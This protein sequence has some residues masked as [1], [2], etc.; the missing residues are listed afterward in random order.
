MDQNGGLM[1]RAAFTA[2]GLSKK[3]PVGPPISNRMSA[4]PPQSTALLTMIT[5]GSPI[6]EILDL[7]GTKNKSFRIH[8]EEII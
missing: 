8:A 6:E 7:F 2:P 4:V 3:K 5:I 1:P